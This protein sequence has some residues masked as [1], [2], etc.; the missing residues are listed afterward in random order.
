LPKPALTDCLLRQRSGT[1]Q[2]GQDESH[3]HGHD[4]DH[5]HKFDEA[6]SAPGPNLTKESLKGRPHRGLDIAVKTTVGPKPSSPL[7]GEHGPAALP[8]AALLFD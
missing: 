6:E 4:R 7:L 3:K 5:N 8:T 1:A 2:R